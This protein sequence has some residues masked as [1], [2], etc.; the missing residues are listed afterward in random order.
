MQ[1]KNVLKVLID[2]SLVK[3]EKIGS[4]NYYWCFPSDSR[5]AVQA[6]IEKLT[7]TVQ[8]LTKEQQELELQIGIEETKRIDSV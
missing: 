7:K 2:N 4:G 3:S 5:V 1:I 8:D 6:R